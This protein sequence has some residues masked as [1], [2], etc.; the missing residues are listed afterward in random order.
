MLL[1]LLIA[2][3]GEDNTTTYE[4]ENWQSKNETYWNSLYATAQQNISSGDKSWKILPVWSRDE[5]PTLKSTDHIVVHVLEQGSGTQQ[6]LYTDTVRVHYAGRLI[7]SPNFSNGYPFDKS[8]SDDSL[9]P[10]ISVPYKNAVSSFVDGFATALL[11]MHVGDS[12]EVY[13]PY[14]LGYGTNANSSTNI[15][16]YSTLI[17]NMTLAG[18]YH[19]GKVVPEWSAKPSFFSW[20]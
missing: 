12:W 3:C 18:I 9:D 16:G 14:T 10:T 7:P 19:P 1:V 5:S 15:P 8:F 17:F 20:E 13:V 11:Y 4:F 6:P 2:S